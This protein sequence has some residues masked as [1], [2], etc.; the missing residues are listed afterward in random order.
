MDCERSWDDIYGLVDVEE[1]TE[2]DSGG[3]ATTP[4]LP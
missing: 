2:A 1:S 4:R 3:H